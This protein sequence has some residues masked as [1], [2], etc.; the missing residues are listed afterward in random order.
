MIRQLV[1]DAVLLAGA[2]G[3]LGLAHAVWLTGF[4]AGWYRAARQS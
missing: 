2:G 3:V 1:S 4:C